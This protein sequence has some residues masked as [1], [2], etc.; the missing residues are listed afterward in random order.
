MPKRMQ[1]NIISIGLLLL[2]TLSCH[3]ISR[4]Q[5]E[6]RKVYIGTKSEGTT[7]VLYFGNKAVPP[8]L[9]EIYTPIGYFQYIDRV[10]LWSNNGGWRK[11]GSFTLVTD[12]KPFLEKYQDDG[13]YY[14]KKRF[15]GTP[16]NWVFYPQMNLWL[17]PERQTTVFSM[18]FSNVKWAYSGCINAQEKVQKVKEDAGLSIV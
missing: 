7:G 13:F 16:N 14:S 4:W 18:S 2:F 8:T 3:A 11:A 6:I 9:T 12:E 10:C 1:Y 15:K 17:D 5:W